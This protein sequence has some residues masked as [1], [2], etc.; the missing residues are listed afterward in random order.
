MP[1]VL[2]YPAYLMG[3]NDTL[4]KEKLTRYEITEQRG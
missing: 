3:V 1:S 4:L 2:A